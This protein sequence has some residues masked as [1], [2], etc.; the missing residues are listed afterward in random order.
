MKTK[1]HFGVLE[2]SISIT[3]V[4]LLMIGVTFVG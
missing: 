1:D 4:V 3:A 2:Y